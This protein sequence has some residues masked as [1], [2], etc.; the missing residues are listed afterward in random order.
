VFY[1][2]VTPANPSPASSPTTITRLSASEVDFNVNDAIGFATTDSA[3]LEVVVYSFAGP[4]EW[5]RIASIVDDSALNGGT[6]STDPTGVI[7]GAVVGSIG[8]LA[9]IAIILFI[10]WRR[11]I[12]D[13]KG[14]GTVGS[15]AL[16][17]PFIRS[18]L[19]IS[20]VLVVEVPEDMQ[21]IF[22]IKSTDLEII[23]KLGEGRFA[24]LAKFS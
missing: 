23:S 10:I 14:T 24:L 11:R 12:R 21:H 20:R 19:I 1:R 6:P 22:N 5:R 7:V 13:I 9:I 15:V 4:S 3:S 17:Q 18:F 2:V 16:S 8:A